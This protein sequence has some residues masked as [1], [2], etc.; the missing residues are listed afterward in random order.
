MP[1][2]SITASKIPHPIAEFRAA[3]IPPRMASAPPVKNPAITITHQCISPVL[4][5]YKF[6]S[7][8]VYSSFETLGFFLKKRTSIIRIL[9][10]PYPLDRT[11][12]RRKQAPPYPEI[13]SQDWCP[14]FYGCDGADA[15]FAVG[16]VSEALYAVP[17]CAA[18][19]LFLR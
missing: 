12:K 18:D 14:R 9:L 10:L 15:S 11:I 19:A 1:T 7:A 6:P 8:V 4:V 3:F 2:P 17:D 5:P 16:G 13:A